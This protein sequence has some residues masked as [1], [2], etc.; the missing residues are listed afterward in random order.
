MVV[1]KLE[2][3]KWIK[4]AGMLSFIPF[5]MIV[6][7][8]AGYFIGGLLVKKFNTPPVAIPISVV[9]GIFVSAVEVIRIVRLVIRI[10]K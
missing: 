6:G 10:N 5:V 4:I 1:N 8:S 3:Y 2:L 9:A 7:I